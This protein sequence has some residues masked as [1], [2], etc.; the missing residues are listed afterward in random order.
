MRSAEDRERAERVC[1]AGMALI[2]EHGARASVVQLVAEAY[3]SV[4]RAMTPEDIAA[5]VGQMI[6]IASGQPV[7]RSVPREPGQEPELVPA[8][9][10]SR[11][12]AAQFLARLIS[13]ANE[14]CGTGPMQRRVIATHAFAEGAQLTARQSAEFERNMR[15]VRRKLSQRADKASL[16]APPSEEK[17]DAQ[18]PE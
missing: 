18:A 11:I 12:R 13:D 6:A 7:R 1:R 8:S 14:Q 9:E 16:P 17:T 15:R 5:V 2:E 10:R 3:R 4:L